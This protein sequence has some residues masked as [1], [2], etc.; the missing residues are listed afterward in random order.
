VPSM[1]AILLV[2]VWLAVAFCVFRGLPVI[3]RSLRNYWGTPAEV[4]GSRI[5]HEGP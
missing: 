1:R 3:I 5:K 4:Q 2:I